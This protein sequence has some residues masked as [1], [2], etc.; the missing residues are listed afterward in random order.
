MCLLFFAID[1]HSDYPLIVAANRDEYYDRPTH[2]LHIWKD[3]PYLIAGKDLHKGGTWFGV[4]KTGRWAAVT[5]YR[6][7]D[8]TA[9]ARSR[10]DL[11]R[12]Y[13][14]SNSSPSAYIDEIKS[15]ALDYNGFNLVIGHLPQAFYFSNRHPEVKALSR[16]VYGLSNDVLDTPWPKVEHGKKG[17]AQLLRFE[18]LS[19]DSLFSLLADRTTAPDNTLPSTGVS[20]EMERLL[21]PGFINGE[22][23]GTRSSTALLINRNNRLKLEE[24]SYYGAP[25]QSPDAYSSIAFEIEISTEPSR[26]RPR[27]SS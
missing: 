26:P 18:N 12:N 3:A 14:A 1:C 4:T 6:E 24:R 20:I 9:E 22:V 19:T 21:S 16:G 17:L 11:V 2:N 7:P 27:S 23:Y 10:G 15:H 13:L 5:N 25:D 8:Q